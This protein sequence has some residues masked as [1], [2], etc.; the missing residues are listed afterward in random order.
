MSVKYKHG[1]NLTKYT[2]SRNTVYHTETSCN[3]HHLSPVSAEPWERSTVWVE[4]DTDSCH[5][6]HTQSSSH[7]VYFV[8]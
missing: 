5:I 4:T 1:T 8:V 7:L 2:K 6:S 3:R